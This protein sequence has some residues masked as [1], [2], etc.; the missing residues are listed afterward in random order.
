MVLIFERSIDH[1]TIDECPGGGMFLWILEDA[2][3]CATVPVMHSES[4]VLEGHIA[5]PGL[6]SILGDLPSNAVHFR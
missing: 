2:L 6:G 5:G 3:D 1:G 4:L